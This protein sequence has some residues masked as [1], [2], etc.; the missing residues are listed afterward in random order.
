MA[1]EATVTPQDARD[2]HHGRA[3]PRRHGRGADRDGHAL[4][5]PPAR[6]V[7]APRP[8]RPARARQGRPA[9]RPAPHRRGRGHRARSGAAPRDRRRRGSA[10]LRL[11][12]HPDGRRADSRR[13]RPVEPAL[14]GLPRRAAARLG[15]R[16]STRRWSRTSCTRSA[17]T[18]ASTCTSSGRTGTTC[19]TSSRASSRGSAARSTRRRRRPAHPRRALDQGL[20]L[21]HAGDGSSSSTTAWGTCAAWRGRSSGSAAQR[22]RSRRRRPSCAPRDADRAAGRRLGARHDGARCA[23]G[24]LDDAV[25]AHIA[26]GRPYLGI[27]LGLQVLLDEAEEGGHRPVPRRRSRVASRASRT[28][29]EPARAA[30]GLE[31]GEARAEHPV[32]AEGYFYFVHGYRATAV[33]TRIWLARTDYGETLRVRDR[34]RARAWPCSSTPRRA[35]A[36]ASS[37]SSASAPGGHDA[38]RASRRLRSALLARLRRPD[39]RP[40]R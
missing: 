35:S 30:H 4:L 10:P 3:A 28:S 17:R 33:P 16:T 37:C 21:T 1:R 25:R 26:A 29:L 40:S 34:P 5:R 22:A 38:R 14:P 9:G 15:R 36:P 7:R 32:I 19:T 2:G 24:G 13:P 11:G 8:V 23:R 12:A 27:C 39:P 6:L 20:A 18:A 31:P